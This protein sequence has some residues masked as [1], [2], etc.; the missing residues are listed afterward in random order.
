[1]GFLERG[2]KW[3][4]SACHFEFVL[5]SD[6]FWVILSKHNVH[7]LKT[8]CRPLLCFGSLHV[9][10][11]DPS[12]EEGTCSKSQIELGGARTRDWTP[13]LCSPAQMYFRALLLPLLSP[14]VT[15]LIP[16]S[17]M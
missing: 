4:C 16:A 17:T 10:D 1:M 3:R 9:T 12:P 15:E 7:C 5:A 8:V 13:G 6:E 2:S 11:E 14:A